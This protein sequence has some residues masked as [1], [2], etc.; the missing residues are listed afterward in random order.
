[1]LCCVR[2]IFLP[3]AASSTF[4]TA[5]SC[6]DYYW[7]PTIDEDTIVSGEVV[8]KLL[9]AKGEFNSSK[10]MLQVW[11]TTPAFSSALPVAEDGE[12]F[13]EGYLWQRM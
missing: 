2:S 3:A 5:I 11:S 9:V 6:A 12:G 10:V 7:K 13:P 4:S 8:R 1:M